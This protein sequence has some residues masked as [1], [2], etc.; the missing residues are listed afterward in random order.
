MTQCRQPAQPARA[1]FVYRYGMLTLAIERT[2]VTRNTRPNPAAGA[3]ALSEADRERAYIRDVLAGDVEAF[4]PLVEA[5]QAQVYNLALRML[6]NEREAE[7]AAQDAFLHAYARLATYKPEWRFKT[8]LMTIASNLCIDRLR[9]RKLE[10]LAFTDVAQREAGD[11]EIEFTSRDPQPDAVVARKQRDEAIR[12][13]L[14]ELPAEDRGM[15][16]MFY[17]NDM[18]Y[19]EIAQATHTTV[20]AVKSRLFRARQ[21]MA[22]SKW[23]EKL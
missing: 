9:R 20:S 7:D 13:M 4:R 12:A 6:G 22:K 14:L 8:W 3:P 23:V 2:A 10:P 17:F 5:Y 21:K 18:S 1:P 11:E 19:E 15:V 16:V